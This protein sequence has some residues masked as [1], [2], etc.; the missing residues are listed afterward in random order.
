MYHKGGH[1]LLNFGFMCQNFQVRTRVKN[2]ATLR[3]I[4]LLNIILTRIPKAPP[5]T[6]FSSNWLDSLTLAIRLGIVQIDRDSRGYISKNFDLGFHFDQLPFLCSRNAA[7]LTSLGLTVN[8][9]SSPRWGNK[10]SE[11]IQFLVPESSPKNWPFQCYFITLVKEMA[12]TPEHL[13]GIFMETF[14]RQAHS[15]GETWDGKHLGGFSPLLPCE[16]TVIRDRGLLTLAHDKTFPVRPIISKQ[17]KVLLMR[18]WINGSYVVPEK[19]SKILRTL[20]WALPFVN[21]L[22][23]PN[24][25]KDWPKRVAGRFQFNAFIS[26]VVLSLHARLL[27]LHLIRVQSSRQLDFLQLLYS[28]CQENE[29]LRQ[30]EYQLLRNLKHSKVKMNQAREI[31][32]FFQSGL[33][34]IYPALAIQG[35]LQMIMNDSSWFDTSLHIISDPVLFDIDRDWIRN[36]EFVT[37]YRKCEADLPQWQSQFVALRPIGEQA[38]ILGF[39]HDPVTWPVPHQCQDLDNLSPDIPEAL[40]MQF[41]RSRDVFTRPNLI[42]DPENQQPFDEPTIDG[43]LIQ[44][45]VDTLADA[46]LSQDEADLH[47]GC[48]EDEDEEKVRIFF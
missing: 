23:I 45:V 26:I 25:F 30:S 28:G 32:G 14:R 17:R 37:L 33:L 22:T 7:H 11:F 39:G 5:T 1:E 16:S 46:D 2:R 41:I 21:S 36:A 8:S 48:D 6:P 4:S 9:V 15:V 29:G 19:P 27:H 18:C 12:L 35:R 24:D 44:T 13:Q 40:R 34:G 38:R 43:G 42:Q 31:V 20:D 10:F 3:M 47:E